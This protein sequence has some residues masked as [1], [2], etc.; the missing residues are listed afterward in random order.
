MRMADGVF[1]ETMPS[2]R[3]IIARED[4]PGGGLDVIPQFSFRG[5]EIP[6]AAH[7]FQSAHLL[8]QALVLEYQLR[9]GWLNCG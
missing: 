3:A 6:R 9:S 1:P 2:R 7:G 5:Q 4:T 8:H